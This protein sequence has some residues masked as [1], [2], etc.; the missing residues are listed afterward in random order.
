MSMQTD[1]HV[2]GGALGRPFAIR[3]MMY[4]TGTPFA[5]G[6]C[7][8]CGCVRLLDRPPD[9]SKSYPA[10]YYSHRPAPATTL[11]RNRPVRRWLTDRR[12]AAQLGRAG[13]PWR[14]LAKLRPADE[15]NLPRWV[16]RL[17]EL[18]TAERILDVGCGTGRLLNQLAVGR[19]RSLVG[20]DPYLPTTAHPRVRLLKLSIEEYDDEPFDIVML[21]HSLEHI[22]D[23]REALAGVRRLLSP[24]GVCLVRVPVASGRPRIVYQEHWAEFDAPRHL[25]LHTRQSMTRL[26]AACGLRV[27]RCWDDSDAF[28]YWCSELYRRGLSLYD[29]AT[30][31]E[32]RPHDYFSEGEL[33][34]FRLQA[35]DDNQQEAGGRTAFVLRRDDQP[36]S[37]A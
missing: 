1:C 11:G 18:A 16:R 32:R 3:E 21:H 14:L 5:Y 7:V 34:A 27:D 20:L 29:S 19:Y 2:C 24:N 8:N 17:P 37:S 23:Q 28:G 35:Q 26:A 30:K 31:R 13:R 25:F 10:D 22:A 36:I 4:G 6:E 15:P 33:E 9:S 12:N